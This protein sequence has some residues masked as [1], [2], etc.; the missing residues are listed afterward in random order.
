MD[1]KYII[2]REV[3]KLAIGRT[4]LDALPRKCVFNNQIAY[5]VPR[6]VWRLW[7]LWREF[8]V[9]EIEAVYNE[10]NGGDFIDVGAFHGFYSLLLGPKAAP[11][12]PLYRWNRAAKRCR[13]C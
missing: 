1:H 12:P 5:K 7:R 8:G 10:Y 11:V 4:L 6:S 13:A 3:R 9:S 2:V